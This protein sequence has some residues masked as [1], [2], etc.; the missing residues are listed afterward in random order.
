MS[1]LQQ[2]LTIQALA[3]LTTGG[4]TP[5]GDFLLLE[6]GD[7]LLQETGDRIKLESSV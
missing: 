2:A 4:I 3:P 7:F 5:P 1:V 6:T